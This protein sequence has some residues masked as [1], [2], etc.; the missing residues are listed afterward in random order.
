MQRNQDESSHG[1][2]IRSVTRG[3]GHCFFGY[4]DKQQW[5]P[6]GRFLLG[7]RAAFADRPVR[8]DDVLEIGMVDLQND[9]RWIPLTVAYVPLGVRI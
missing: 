2:S 7:M 5:D 1:V 3:S 8:A 9:D 4:Y 6:T